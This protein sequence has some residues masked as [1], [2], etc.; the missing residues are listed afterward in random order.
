[1]TAIW[2][3]LAAVLIAL[4]PVFIKAGQSGQGGKPRKDDGTAGISSGSDG[5]SDGGSSDSCDT[6]SSSGDCGGGD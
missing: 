3:A 1:M 4:I 5:G 2:I 6:G